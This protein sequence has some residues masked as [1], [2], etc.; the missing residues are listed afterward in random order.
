M[1]DADI[2]LL[3]LE[4]EAAAARNANLSLALERLQSQLE[5]SGRNISDSHRI[6]SD[7]SRLDSHVVLPLRPAA[8]SCASTQ[9]SRFYTEGEEA[10]RRRVLARL[11][12]ALQD[13]VECIALVRPSNRVSEPERQSGS[14][15]YAIEKLANTIASHITNLKEACKAR[16]TGLEG[17]NMELKKVVDIQRNQIKND[18]LVH[19]EKLRSLEE[20]IVAL[21]TQHDLLQDQQTHSFQ[22]GNSNTLSENERLKLHNEALTSALEKLQHE[23][24]YVLPKGV[25]LNPQSF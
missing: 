13:I 1:S 11:N 16:I 19:K 17:Q 24:T 3:T 25:N 2:L 10:D 5:C 14:E 6:D 15:Y 22:Q 18:A 23:M 21:Q 4:V 20:K 9:T 7:L 8:T 12:D